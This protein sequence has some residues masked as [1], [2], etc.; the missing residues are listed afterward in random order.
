MLHAGVSLE[1]LKCRLTFSET[2]REK[3]RFGKVK[4]EIREQ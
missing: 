4:V 3:Q 2:S 1:G